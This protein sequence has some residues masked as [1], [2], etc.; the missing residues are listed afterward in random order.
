[1]LVQALRA[2]RSVPVAS[3]AM[4]TLLVPV[5]LFISP[6]TCSSR[7]FFEGVAEGSTYIKSYMN[8]PTPS[9]RS[10]RPRPPLPFLLRRPM[11]PRDSTSNRW[12][13]ERVLLLGLSSLAEPPQLGVGGRVAQRPQRR[14]VRGVGFAHLCMDAV[15]LRKRTVSDIVGAQA[16]LTIV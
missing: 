15:L 11:Q 14:G 13:E 4:L 16:R 1:M 7:C 10:E 12:L 5:A 2:C 3:Q 8:H 9:T 6:S